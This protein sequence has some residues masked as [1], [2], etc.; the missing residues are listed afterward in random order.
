LSPVRSHQTNCGSPP[1]GENTLPVTVSSS[2]L[3]VIA[4]R[5]LPT[6]LLMSV[7]APSGVICT[8][9]GRPGS[10]STPSASK[11]RILGLTTPLRGSSIGRPVC[12]SADSAVSTSARP[13]F[14]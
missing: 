7:R 2:G 4:Q 8:P 1:P 13:S 12:C 10:G 9:D 11:I 14:W 3:Y 6:S 5:S